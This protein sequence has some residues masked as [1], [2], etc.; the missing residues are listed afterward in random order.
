MNDD[1]LRNY[2]LNV[3]KLCRDIKVI[4]NLIDGD[5]YLSDVGVEFDMTYVLKRIERTKEFE[6]Q[7][8]DYLKGKVEYDHE[9]ESELQ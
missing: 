4:S 5:V 6:K 9:K 3:K 2:V 1:I 8:Q 7:I